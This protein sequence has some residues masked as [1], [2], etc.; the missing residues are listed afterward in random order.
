[1]PTPHDKVMPEQATRFV[2]YDLAVKSLS[3]GDRSAATVPQVG[4][5]L[6]DHRRPSVITASLLPVRGHLQ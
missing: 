6:S 2:T 5:A 4:A 3:G 1:M